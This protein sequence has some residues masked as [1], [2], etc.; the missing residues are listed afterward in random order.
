MSKQRPDSKPPEKP[1]QSVPKHR[2]C[3]I[4]Y[5]GL[6]GA[7]N[8]RFSEKISGTLQRRYYRCNQC[9]HHWTVD[10]RSEVVAMESKTFQV[11]ENKSGKNGTA[12][13]TQ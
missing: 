1:K 6:G 2:Q 4:C 7:G 8:I 9:G 11:E 5:R 13:E 10:V 12:G 3:P